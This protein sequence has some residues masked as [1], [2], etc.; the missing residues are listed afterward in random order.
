MT[1]WVTSTPFLAS[2]AASATPGCLKPTNNPPETAALC[3]RNVRRE[4]LN[5]AFMS[6]S[7]YAAIFAAA[8]IASRTR[9]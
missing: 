7:P 2:S 6:R 4:A 8:W 1:Q 5:V 3:N 9:T